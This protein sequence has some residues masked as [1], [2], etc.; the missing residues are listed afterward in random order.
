MHIAHAVHTVRHCA[1]CTAVNIVHT[2]YTLYILRETKTF[3]WCASHEQCSHGYKIQGVIPPPA[4]STGLASR[5]PN[6]R[7]SSRYSLSASSHSLSWNLFRYACVSR[8]PQAEARLKEKKMETQHGGLSE[9]NGQ[10]GAS[11]NY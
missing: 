11:K 6:S 9:Q 7:R 8:A 3:Q 2:P 5:K 10:W 4:L 1:W